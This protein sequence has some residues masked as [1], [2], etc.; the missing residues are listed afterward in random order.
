MTIPEPN[1]T[2]EKHY[3]ITCRVDDMNLEY[4]I[5]IVISGEETVY[6]E[7]CLKDIKESRVGQICKSLS[8]YKKE[9]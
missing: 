2:M 6:I 7:E 9:E 3:I 4:K 8:L 5:E 1:Q